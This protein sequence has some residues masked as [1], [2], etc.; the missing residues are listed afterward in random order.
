MSDL[1]DEK[2]YKHNFIDKDVL[3]WL[4]WVLLIPIAFLL[5]VP[6]SDIT[7]F[8]VH[9][10]GYHHSYITQVISDILSAIIIISVAKFI[11]PSHKKIVGLIIVILFVLLIILTVSVKTYY[12]INDDFTTED[13][14]S[15]LYYGSMCITVIL[16]N[17][18]YKGEN[19]LGLSSDF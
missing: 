17:I 16:I 5:S 11:A 12:Y 6:T 4:R 2:E 3:Y 18:F 15:I 7:T 10:F 14:L 1:L 19:F 13:S 9:V 8:I